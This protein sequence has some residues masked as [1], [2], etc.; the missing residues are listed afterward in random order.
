MRTTLTALIHVIQPFDALEQEHIQTTLTWI[1][2]GAALFRVAKPA[3]PPQHLVS[4]FVLVDPDQKKLLLVDHK[5][6]GLWLPG[7][8]HVEPDEHPQATVRREIDE[9]LGIAANFLFAEPLFLTVTKT[10]GATPGHTDVSL[11]YG[12]CGDSTAPLNFDENEF[13][14]IRWFAFDALPLTHADP[15]LA[16]FMA[17]LKRRLGS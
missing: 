5:N 3:T 1:A 7:G 12:L 15:H 6:A 13:H 10:V 2:S 4:Y 8:G 9:E 14:A 11:W 17:K 16:R